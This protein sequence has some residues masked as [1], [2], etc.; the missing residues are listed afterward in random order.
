MQELIQQVRTKGFEILFKPYESQSIKGYRLKPY[1]R[2]DK[3]IVINSNNE[4]EVQYNTLLLL[5]EIS[6]NYNEY[7]LITIAG[8]DYNIYI[9][10]SII[11]NPNIIKS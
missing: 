1:N 11:N 9:D 10:K 3:Y 4:E 6:D 2:N 8:G 5:N 7:E